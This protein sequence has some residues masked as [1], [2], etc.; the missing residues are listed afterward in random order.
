MLQD[1]PEL[2]EKIARRPADAKEMWHLANNCYV[3]KAFDEAAHDRCRDE[4]SHPTH[5][6]DSKGKEKNADHDSEG[7]GER[8]KFGTTRSCDGAD[9]Y[10]RDQ[11]PAGVPSDDD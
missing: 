1:M 7:G 5:A 10:R 11:T 4:A 9:S 8:I 3:D 6:H 2:C